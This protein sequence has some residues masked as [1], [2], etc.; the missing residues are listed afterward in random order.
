MRLV[1][2]GNSETRAS[3]KAFCGPMCV[4]QLASATAKT[5]PNITITAIYC[6]RILMIPSER[7]L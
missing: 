2:Y 7:R 6:K 1:F 4:G 3:A 5:I